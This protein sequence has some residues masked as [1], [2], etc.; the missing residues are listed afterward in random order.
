MILTQ[1]IL[2]SMIPPSKNVLLAEM[3][4]MTIIGK[5]ETLLNLVLKE[6]F[7]ELSTQLVLDSQERLSPLLHSRKCSDS[8]EIRISALL[9][10][11]YHYFL[12]NNVI[13]CCSILRDLVAPYALTGFGLGSTYY[14]YQYAFFSNRS[15]Q[16]LADVVSNGLFF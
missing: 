6:L 15:N 10:K 4:F 14:L 9:G 16:Y 5:L 8:S 7:Q 12:L 13:I 11:L 1:F 2:K 3:S